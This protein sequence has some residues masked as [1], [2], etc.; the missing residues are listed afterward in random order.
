MQKLHFSDPAVESQSFLTLVTFLPRSI[1]CN[2]PLTRLQKCPWEES[3]VSLILVQNQISHF[4]DSS[5]AS[6]NL[7]CGPES[8]ICCFLTLMQ[9]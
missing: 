6:L 4:I 1:I 9:N 5:A 7:P 2:F 3:V 8:G